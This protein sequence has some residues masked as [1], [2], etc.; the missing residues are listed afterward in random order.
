MF[1]ELE[2]GKG[3]VV[4]A[5]TMDRPG[6][7]IAP[8]RSAGTVGADASCELPLMGGV[9]LRFDTHEQA[10]VVREALRSPQ[11]SQTTTANP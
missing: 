7:V 8:A 2:F 10:I 6:V 3:Q 1:V 5:R 11:E 4:V 9:I